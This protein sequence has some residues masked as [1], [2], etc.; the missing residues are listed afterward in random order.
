MVKQLR[1]E[2]FA[3]SSIV[4]VSRNNGLAAAAS[5]NLRARFKEAGCTFKVFKNSLTKIAT[6]GTAYESLNNVLVG[7]ASLA[8]ASDPVA[9]AKLLTEFAKENEKLEIVGGV[10]NGAFMD[11]KAIST[12]ATLP[13]LDELRGKI[14]GLLQAPASKLAAV[15]QAPAAKV[16]RVLKAYADKNN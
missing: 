2:V 4:I 10:M 16:A 3:T 14:V 12:L 7:P 11:S 9:V 13:S 8:Y 6:K 5:K 15:T 1:D